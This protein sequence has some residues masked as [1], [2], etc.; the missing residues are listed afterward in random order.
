MPSTTLRR[1]AA[2]L[3]SASHRPA[4]EAAADG[5][6]E[7]AEEIVETAQGKGELIE[8]IADALAEASGSAAPSHQGRAEHELVNRLLQEVRRCA[9]PYLALRCLPIVFHLPCGD[10]TQRDLAREFGLTPGD[11]SKVC[12]ALQDRFGVVGRGMRKP[13]TRQKYAERQKGRRA[14][15]L[16][17]PYGWRGIA[18]GV[19][20]R[21][22]GRVQGANRKRFPI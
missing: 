15:P 6:R 7:R 16:A 9:N 8:A 17:Q 10:E 5:W 21:F 4:I 1:D 20:E 18:E 19:K 2:E 13:E 22:A 11:V 3:P 12:T 14:R